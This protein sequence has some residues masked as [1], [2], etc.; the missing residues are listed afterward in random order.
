VAPA[1]LTRPPVAPFSRATR[2]ARFQALDAEPFDLVVVGAGI[3]GAGVAR[4]A[5]MRGLRTLLVDKGDLACGTSSASSKLV[6]GGLRYLEQYRFGLV[7]ESLSERHRLG[8]LAPHLVRPLRFVFPVFERRPRPM[9]QVTAAMWIYDTLAM[10]R[11]HRL[12][13]RHG[14][15]GAAELEPAL[16]TE[17]LDGAVSYFDCVTDDARLTLETARAAHEAGA[18]VVT[19]AA[20]RAFTSRRGQ[21]TGVEIEDVASGTLKTVSARVVLNATGPWTDRTRGLRGDRTRVLR[22]TKGV[23]LVVPRARLPLQHA[24]ATADLV[25]GR[26]LFALPF[27][28]RIALGTTDTDFDADY[29]HV[30]ATRE[31]VDSLLELAAY[32]FPSARLATADVV[33]TFAGLRPLLASDGAATELSREHLLRVD[34]DGLIT[35]AGGKLTTYRSMAGEVVDLVGRRLRTEGVHVGGCPTGAVPLPGGAG[36]RQAGSRLRTAGPEG[37]AIDREAE[38][39]LGEDVV[40]H[41]QQTHGGRWLELAQRAVEDPEASRRVVADLPY[42]WAEVDLAVEDELATTLE[43]VLRRRTQLQLR[44]FEQGL[45]VADAV[46]R[47]MAPKLG[48]DEVRIHDELRRYAAVV[49]ASRRWSEST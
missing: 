40:E 25:D 31:D 1:R 23:H 20:V 42:L 17:G 38:G 11:S 34:D 49:A 35:I 13:R 19:Y 16:R 7:F 45:E 2:D 18:H 15:R 3:T 8:R 36:I 29:D 26:N 41:L 10:F 24:V 30:D 46:A 6:H 39:R 43:D 47:R 21:V 9:W 12:H 22:P 48:W 4:D 33:S 44:D 32:A 28:N 14:A 5:A 37:E 27:G